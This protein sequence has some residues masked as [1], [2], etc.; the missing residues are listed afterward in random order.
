MSLG[1]FCVRCGSSAFCLV[2]HN[3]GVKSPVSIKKNDASSIESDVRLIES[4][5]DSTIRGHLLKPAQHLQPAPFPQDNVGF[6]QQSGLSPFADDWVTN[7]CEMRLSV[8]DR[9]TS[10]SGLATI[11]MLGNTDS[12]NNP[13]LFYQVYCLMV[14]AQLASRNKEA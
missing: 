7:N 14:F 11:R 5:E 2:D 10:G 9:L 13:A 6:V 1:Y 8:A 12:L 3:N 4:T